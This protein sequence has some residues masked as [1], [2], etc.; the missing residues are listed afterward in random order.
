MNCDLIRKGV[1]I[2]VV[3]AINL[4]HLEGKTEVNWVCLSL[5]RSGLLGVDSVGDYRVL[6]LLDLPASV[7]DL[8]KGLV[9]VLVGDKEAFTRLNRISDSLPP[10][11]VSGVSR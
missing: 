9:S 5:S 8:V 1:E 7:V 11:V 6:S 10:V 4:L 3:A 2:V